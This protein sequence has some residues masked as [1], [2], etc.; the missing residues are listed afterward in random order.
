MTGDALADQSGGSIAARPDPAWL[1]GSDFADVA[2]GSF[3][4]I[5]VALSDEFD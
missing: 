2:D 5:E 1:V 4:K 3:I